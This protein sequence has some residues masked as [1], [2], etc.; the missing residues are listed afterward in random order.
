LKKVADKLRVGVIFGGRS[1]EH[2]V[3][4]MSAKNIIGLLSQA[5]YSIVP[6][7]ITHQGQWLLLEDVARIIRKMEKDRKLAFQDLIP[8]ENAPPSEKIISCLKQS[9]DVVFPLIHGKNGE[10]GTLQGV[11]ELAD[12]AYVGSGVLAS[13][14]AM[15]KAATKKIL[16]A[17]RIPVVDALVVTRK[18]WRHSPEEIS[19]YVDEKSHYPC[20]VKPVNTG[21]SIGV[22]KVHSQDELQ[23]ALTTAA[24]YDRRMLVEEAVEGRE[25]T[26]A[27]IG[28]EDPI[29]SV[30]GEIVTTREFYDY[31][32]KY[33]EGSTELRIP[34]DLPP[35]SAE[36]IRKIAI[37]AFKAL[38]CAGM[39]RVDFFL[40]RSGKIYVN[41]VN[42][43]PGFTSYSMYPKLWE[44]TGMDGRTLLGRLLDL[45][46][47]RYRDKYYV[48]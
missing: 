47:E 39:A 1:A 11:L 13:A 26:V 15:D 30:P 43:I 48:K 37:D 3:S 44:H 36:K 41:E 45:A 19:K 29:V 22:S 2:D 9:V 12:V 10:D 5:K 34:A 8:M 16:S 4:I 25:I 14:L 7:G 28:N 17:H 38:D 31:E 23:Q 20:F 27:V 21:S 46:M 35:R 33:T 42:T 6:I 32:A 40:T 24:A 18:M